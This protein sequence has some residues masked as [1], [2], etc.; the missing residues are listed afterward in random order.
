MDISGHP[1]ITILYIEKFLNWEAGQQTLLLFYHLSV[2]RELTIYACAF[3]KSLFLYGGFFLR[4]LYSTSSSDNLSLCV[5][6]L[7][8]SSFFLS[9]SS[10]VSL[11][12][13]PS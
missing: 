1:A 3:I 9:S 10:Q 2:Y 6:L 4:L 12:N 13:E 11:H 7:S 5:V 8:S